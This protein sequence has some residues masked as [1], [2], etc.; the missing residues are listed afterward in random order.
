MNARRGRRGGTLLALLLLAAAVAGAQPAEVTVSRVVGSGGVLA[1]YFENPRDSTISHYRVS[2]W[3]ST[4]GWRTAAFPASEARESGGELYVLVREVDEF[5]YDQG[6]NDPADDGFVDQIR[7]LTGINVT[8]GGSGY[9]SSP[10]VNISGSGAG[11]KD[12][13][14]L[15]RLRGYSPGGSLD[16]IELTNPCCAFNDLW[17]TD[18]E[19]VGGGGTGGAATVTA[20]NVAGTSPRIR[21]VDLRDPG[22]GYTSRP[23]ITFVDSFGNGSGA[24]SDLT[25]EVRFSVTSITVDNGG[26]GYTTAP[27]VRIHSS[28]TAGGIDATATAVVQNGA[29]TS[30]TVVNPGNLYR[31]DRL[32]AVEIEHPG[33][34]GTRATAT[35]VLGDGAVYIGSEV[36]NPPEGT[37][38]TFTQVDEDGAFLRGTEVVV[39]P[40]PS[41]RTAE[42]VTPDPGFVHSKVRGVTGVDITSAG[43]GYTSAPAVNFFSTRGGGQPLTGGILPTAVAHVTPSV[44]GSG[45]VERID[46]SETDLRYSGVPTVTISGG[47][48]TGATATAVMLDQ[49]TAE[50]TV[51]T[52]YHAKVEAMASGVWRTYTPASL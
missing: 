39:Q 5:W 34:S 40:P 28:P 38:Y 35:A 37:C 31:Q 48:G 32:P 41:G 42:I 45:P 20:G 36:N 49:D 19:L 13:T 25:L 8:N 27:N 46:L 16:R 44:E 4:A 29:V 18:V 2:L 33:G 7:T 9:T 43:S 30:I 14:G 3:T 11:G 26:A 17:L 51:G 50:L 22:S 1:V 24:R 47:G 6:T 23:G 12:T 10:I 15:A 52:T 21:T